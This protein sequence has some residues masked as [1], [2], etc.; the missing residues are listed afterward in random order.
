MRSNIIIKKQL[1]IGTLK[2]IK[3]KHFEIIN[4]KCWTLFLNITF[5]LANEFADFNKIYKKIVND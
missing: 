3:N 4:L 1:L 2:R 5:R